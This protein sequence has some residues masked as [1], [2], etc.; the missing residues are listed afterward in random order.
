M[1]QTGMAIL[2][3]PSTQPD[4]ALERELLAGSG[5][6][7]EPWYVSQA[8]KESHADP[9]GHYLREGWRLGLEPNPSFPGSLLQPCFA[10]LGVTEAPAITWLMLGSA[11][12]SLPKC[13]EE[14]EASASAL[15]GT[16]LF[17]EAFYAN[18]IGG[19]AIG[20]DLAIHYL[21][22]GER[23]GFA[24]SR[25]FDPAYY[26]AIHSDI[27][28]A[29]LNC[30]LHYAAHGR[31]EGRRG[32]PARVSSPGRAIFDPHKE[33]VILVVHE[34]SRTGAPILGWN[35]AL[36]LAKRYNVFTVHLG[37]GELT[38]SFEAL[39]VELHGPFLESKRN[40]IDIEYSLRSLLDARR[41]RY[42]I[43][44]S[45]ESRLIVEPCMRR[46]IPTVLLMHEFASYVSPLT[47]DWFSEIVF[48]A[49]MVAQSAEK[50]YPFIR[51]RA[52]HVIPQGV[53]AL[54][55]SSVQRT[56]DAVASSALDQLTT[57]HNVEGTLIVLG[58]GLVQV[59]KGVDLF[60]ATAAAVIRRRPRRPI[61]F[62]WVGDGYQP[63]KDVGYSVYLA[64]QIARSGLAEHVTFI[65]A[66][67]DLEPIYCITDAFLLSSRLDPLP[68]VTI[69][70][71]VRGIP[72]ICFKDASGMADLML[73]DPETALGVVDYVDAEGAGN[74]IFELAENEIVR[75]RLGKAMREL[76]R[77]NFDME[78]YIARLDELGTAA[79]VRMNQQSAD[80][81]TLRSD[82]TFD[83]DMYL[84]PSPLLETREVTIARYL[85]IGAARGWQ[86][87]PNQPQLIR[88]PAPGFNA[89]TYAAAHAERLAGGINPLADFIRRGKP[90]GPWQATVLRPD[91]PGYELTVGRL[92][93]ALHAHMF[94]PDLFPDFLG[95]LES[96][97]IRCDLLIST[98]TTAKAEQ[99][100][101]LLRSYAKGR[102]DLRVVPNKGRDIGPLLTEFAGCLNSYDLVGHV[103]SK[104]SLTS[105]PPLNEN[106]WGD[107]WREFLWQNL[108]GGLYPMMDRIVGAFERQ[109]TL[110]LVFPSDPNMVGWD[111]NRDLAA[112]I[113]ARMGWKRP[114]PDYFDFPLGTMFWMRRDALQPLID[115][116]LSWSDYP[117][118]PGPYDGTIL[119]A[120]ERL[121]PIACQLAGFTQAVTHICGVSWCP[122]GV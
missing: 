107:A 116:G 78:N 119:H 13:R 70:A 10:T 82:P 30:L 67:P 89:R 53:V 18:Q 99:L 39:S 65:D 50:T 17:D 47:L 34:T 112:D 117:E 16:G 31:A 35:I 59:R 115:L 24:P 55:P 60:L 102:I 86:T 90:T 4:L 41:Y 81:Q 27:C 93:V 52:I 105:T 20:L 68:N 42:V 40:E 61:H 36:H 28:Q 8:G 32:H 80:A 101:R 87:P 121:V 57:K 9:I 22:V 83:Q 25:D 76:A 45:S 54:P 56:Q 97:E 110:G 85:A 43:V 95:H 94:Y 12:W 88:R 71:A 23:M 38:G 92:R 6:F 64:E 29:G 79:A 108:L 58:A 51:S 69:D 49:R 73:S 19:R 46:L 1:A 113:A 63:R 122:G 96:N 100:E 11:G 2:P 120:L 66:V 26:A 37:G 7:D 84:G 109:N 3:S 44:N 114:L 5:L 111:T 106:A 118:E 14:L 21:T 104:R 62:L 75:E 33:N 77:A 91:D 98:D 72:V 74:V 15:R 48:S 103:H